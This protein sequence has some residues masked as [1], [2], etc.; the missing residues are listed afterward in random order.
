MP[1]L[2]DML[3]PW[4]VVVFN[5]YMRYFVFRFNWS[6]G[7]TIWVPGESCTHAGFPFHNASFLNNQLNIANRIL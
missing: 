6:Y 1:F 7:L 4:R 3:V 2:G 5:L